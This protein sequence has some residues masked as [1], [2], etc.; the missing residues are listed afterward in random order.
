MDGGHFPEQ[1]KILKHTIGRLGTHQKV[2]SQLVKARA[3]FPVFF[4]SQ[5]VRVVFREPPP[6]MPSILATGTT[7]PDGIVGRIFSDSSE[8]KDFKEKLEKHDR[9]IRGNDPKGFGIANKLKEKHKVETRV[10]AEIQLLDYFY[11]TG[12]RFFNNVAYIGCSKPACYL[13]AR[14]VKEH[15]CQVELRGTHEKIYLKWR[16]PDEDQDREIIREMINVIR[17]DVVKHLNYR[18]ESQRRV[19][20]PDTTTGLSTDSVF[21]QSG[22]SGIESY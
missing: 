10:H 15:P 2:L 7:T 9:I 14:Y 19:W 13:C 8:I 21:N 5:R 1:L 3:V 17:R 16:V 11:K 4:N 22:E 6:K 20:H 12:A 18:V